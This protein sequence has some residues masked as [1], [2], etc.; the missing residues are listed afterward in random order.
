MIVVDASVLIEVLVRPKERPQIA[1][2][3]L[4]PDE[5]VHVPHLVDVEVA[6]VMRRFVRSGDITARLGKA[7]LSDL[8][9]FPLHR[10]GHD[11]LLPRVWE[12]RE[13][14]TAYDA[15]YVALAELL[16]VVLLTRDRKLAG[17]SGL[18]AKIELV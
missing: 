5:Q 7:I 6:Q 16:E 11:Y 14:L 8:A 3:I 15:V 10:H 17:A 1:E 13:N 4:H 18:R 9:V 2:R 12:L